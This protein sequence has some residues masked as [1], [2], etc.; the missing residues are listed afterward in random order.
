MVPGAGWDHP[1]RMR[2]KELQEQ[3]FINTGNGQLHRFDVQQEQKLF[4]SQ[5]T[6]K[7][8]RKGTESTRKISKSKFPTLFHHNHFLRTF[9]SLYNK[10]GIETKLSTSGDNTKQIN[11][12]NIKCGN[13]K[14]QL[15]R[16][17]KYLK[18]FNR[19]S[20]INGLQARI[21]KLYPIFR[22]IWRISIT[23]RIIRREYSRWGK[24]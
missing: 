16:F 11:E 23:N 13:L 4:R 20:N 19:N 14:G 5:V 24:G 21:E 15:T 17:E 6:P 22:L 9:I 1:K 18:E 3:A 8:G 2:R 10:G 12:L 7:D